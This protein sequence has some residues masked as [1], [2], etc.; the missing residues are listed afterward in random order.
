MGPTQESF[1][2]AVPEI[3]GPC[4]EIWRGG[5]S[6]QTLLRRFAMALPVCALLVTLAYL[7]V[8]R[9]VAFFVHDHHLNRI[10][11]LEWMTHTAMAF[12]ALASAIVFLAAVRLAFG[13]LTRLERTLFAAALSLM[14][15]VAFEYYLKFLF[16]RYWPE[17][18]V[19][20]N[21]SLIRDNAYGFHPFHDG[22]AYGSFPS[23][24][25]ARTVALLW[26]I[27][28]AYPR[29]VW[30]CVLAAASVV[31]GLVG[32][33]Y[34][35]VGDTIGGTFLGAWTGMYA[36]RFFR[37][38]PSVGMPAGQDDGTKPEW[39]ADG[40][41]RIRQSSPSLLRRTRDRERG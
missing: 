17:T 14:V 18:W 1:P 22:S 38:A 2:K 31:V 6:F 25:T 33:N 16:G 28:V 5:P 9:P 7:F 30:L 35:F 10:A 3:D 13:P 34:H 37:V 32:M 21:P 26:V 24:H 40:E 27:G 39:S 19:N 12:D 36:A 11:A 41:F 15:A 20:D 8:D 29:W 23:G 4:E